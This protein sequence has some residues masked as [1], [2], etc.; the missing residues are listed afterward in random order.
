K[1]VTVAP[2]TTDG[3]APVEFGITCHLLERAEGI[4]R[5]AVPYHPGE[6]A[7]ARC[8]ISG[9]RRESDGTRRITG[10][11]RLLDDRGKQMFATTDR[12]IEGRQPV[13]FLTFK[14]SIPDSAQPGRYQLEGAVHDRVAGKDITNVQSLTITA[15]AR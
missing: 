13:F 7:F 11:F 10:H 6:T 5:D 9:G 14:F 1:T 2:A 15:T 3:G 8:D 12:E 4:S